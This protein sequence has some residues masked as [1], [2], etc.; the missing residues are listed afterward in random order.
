MGTDMLILLDVSSSTPTND[1]TS[2]ISIIESFL[3]QVVLSDENMQ[4]GILPFSSTSKKM[5]G[6]STDS[7]EIIS[8]AQH[9]QNDKEENNLHLVLEN[10][11]KYFDALPTNRKKRSVV[12]F[13]S[14][15]AS[16][17]KLQLIKNSAENLDICNTEIL[18]VG[19]GRHVEDTLY[20]IAGQGSYA[21]LD[22]WGNLDTWTAKLLE[23][24]GKRLCRSR[25]CP[26][27]AGV[28]LFGHM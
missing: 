15:D 19:F 2:Y 27:H 5:I 1:L 4:V 22:V 9:L 8:Q 14:D 24:V 17:E 10:L 25:R 7:A 6:F 23:V 11:P 28:R 16:N 13:T 20:E 3:R 12:V 18:A 26:G 21:V